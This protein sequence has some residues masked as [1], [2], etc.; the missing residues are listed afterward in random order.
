MSAERGPILRKYSSTGGVTFCQPPLSHRFRLELV[1]LG[2][3]RRRSRRP[4][5]DGMLCHNLSR[6]H[7]VFRCMANSTGGPLATVVIRGK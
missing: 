6:L 2:W 3:W 1:A 5:V 7:E 4:R